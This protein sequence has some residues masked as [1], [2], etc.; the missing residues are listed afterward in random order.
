MADELTGFLY[1]ASKDISALETL[2][3][4]SVSEHTEAI[5]FHAQ[6][7]AEKMLKSIFLEKGVPAP[8][9]HDLVHLLEVARENEWI[10]CRKRE[11]EAAMSLSDYAVAARYEFS[12]EI[13]EGE[14]LQ[15]IAYCNDIA[16]LLERNRFTAVRADSDAH[17]LHDE[18]DAESN[19]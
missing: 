17:F 16:G 6:Q 8:R 14:A 10:E 15:A 4:D 13:G 12:P 19:E 5:A 11:I 1:A 3:R 18:A 2:R 7:A 9:T